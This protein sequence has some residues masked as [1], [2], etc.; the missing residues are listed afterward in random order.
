M[1]ER[2]VLRPATVDDLDALVATV[3]QEVIRW[4][5]Y[6]SEPAQLRKFIDNWLRSEK[7]MP[8]Y[9]HWIICDRATSDVIGSRSLWPA[10]G[11][12]RTCETGSWLGPGWRRH[13][14]GV[15]EL[16]AVLQF[17]EGY[18]SYTTVVAGTEA[19]NL[20]ARRQYER[21]GFVVVARPD[22]LLH[23]L[24]DGRTVPATWLC[25]TAPAN[26]A[27]RSHR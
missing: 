15:E 12:H 19:T 3:D 1:T 4:Q 10:G 5:G 27:S 18:L 20:A 22:K 25:R 21:C 6:P 17:V 26:G 9:R 16:T 2:L 24:P 14:L 8:T 11:T 13:G 7:R 23:Q